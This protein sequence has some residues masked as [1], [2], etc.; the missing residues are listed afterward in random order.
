MDNK[1]KN[2]L[3][4]G[5]ISGILEATMTWPM[6]NIKTRMQLKNGNNLKVRHIY[7]IIQ[8]EGL[9][10][11]YRGL[12]PILASNIP[13]VGL[14]F[15][16]FEKVNQSINKINPNSKL[17]SLYAGLVSGIIESTFVTVPSETIKTKYIERPTTS[18]F[19]IIKT[20]GIAGMYKGYVSTTGRQC[21]NQS[22][23]FFFYQNYKDFYNKTY[24]NK[25]FGKMESFIGGTT[26][27]L[28]SVFVSQPFDVIKTKGQS[29]QEGNKSLTQL[30][31]I[32]KSEYGIQGFWRGS[33]P[34]ILR[35]APGQGVMFLAYDTI[36][37]YLEK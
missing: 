26:A 32:V 9:L 13:K 20:E 11:V 10:S 3:I 12:T 35:V 17:N 19:N 25:E 8:K 33:V 15:L 2:T 1:S 27:G 34:R 36:M 31:Q 16:V 14:R 23:R 30:A 5:S 6:E 37:K 28:L 29:Y 7:P 4:A 18:I 21:M 24:P 22:S